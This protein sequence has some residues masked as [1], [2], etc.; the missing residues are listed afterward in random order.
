ME[1]LEAARDAIRAALA[2]G[3]CPRADLAARLQARGQA[4]ALEHLVALPQG[5]AGR[6]ARPP[7]RRREVG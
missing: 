4:A 1:T 3:R 7:R 2:G 5:G 6:R